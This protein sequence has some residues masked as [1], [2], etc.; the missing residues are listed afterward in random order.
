[1]HVG[2]ETFI[3][4]YGVMAEAAEE[5]GTQPIF[6]TPVSPLYCQGETA[7]GIRGAYTDATF[8]AGQRFDVPVIDLNK[9]SND[10]YNELG[11]CPIPQDFF[12]GEDERL[13][14][15]QEGAIHIAQLVAEAVREQNIGLAAYIK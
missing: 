9:L 5:R 15:S 14:F 1:M 7:I 13:H 8:E 4:Y 2:T 10:L 11:L 12:C 3:G 6:V